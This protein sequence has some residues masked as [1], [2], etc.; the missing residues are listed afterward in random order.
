MTDLVEFKRM[1]FF[2]GFF[3]TAE[4]WNQGQSYTIEKRKL[5]NRGLHT[6]G[7]I[8][9]EGQELQVEAA[10]GLDVR[11]LPGAALDSDGNDIYLWQPNNLTINPDEYDLPQLVDIAIQYAEEPSDYVENVEAP[12]YSGHTR[13][14]E[15]PCLQVVSTRPDNQTSIELARIDLQPDVAEITAPGD[16]ANPGGNEID[17]RYV[18]WAGSVGV[19]EPRLAPAMREQIILLAQ[20]KRRDFAALDR[21]FPVPSAGDV[22]HAALTVEMLVRTDC[23]RPEP[24]AGL[25][26]TI[27]A[28]E[29]DVG[30]EIE[31]AYPAVITTAEFTAYRDAVAALLDALRDGMGLDTLIARQGAVAEAAREL[32]EVALQPPEPPIADAG[33]DSAILTSREEGIATLDASGSKAFAG[34]AIVRYRW[35][36]QE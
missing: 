32:S 36:R 26:A 16:P 30:Q 23:L 34:R 33:P 28:L 17:R 10:G 13:V 27:A 29:Q 7:V 9:G 5:H 24:L 6:P 18:I 21:R 19:A 14:A 31:A 12:H 4:D 25:L 20:D 3:T 15:V 8:K 22:R 35:E 2:T 11:V 1:N